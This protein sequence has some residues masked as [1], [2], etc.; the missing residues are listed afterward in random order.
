MR[1]LPLLLLL[2]H[3]VSADRLIIEKVECKRVASGIDPWLKHAVGGLVGIIAGGAVALA[4]GTVVIA[5]DGAMVGTIPV[6]I[7]AI[8]SAAS[9]GNTAAK[10]AIGFIESPTTDTD[11]LIIHVN[12]HKVY[13]KTADYGGIE[14]GDVIEEELS[15]NFTRG[16]EIQLLEHDWPT[17]NDDLGS[18]YVSSDAFDKVAPGENY[19]VNQAVVLGSEEEGSLYLV[20][21]R[22]ERDEQVI[23]GRW[24]LCGTNQCKECRWSM[25]QGADE[26]DV[27][28]D[29]DKSD[30]RPCPFPMVHRGYKTFSMLWPVPDL[31]CRICSSPVL[32]CCGMAVESRDECDCS[33]T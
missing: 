6:T 10:A 4:G 25:C 5:S 26:E 7:G 14:A 3:S 32:R 2:L 29:K 1:S 28:R 30:L 21:Y 22:V 19:R 20:T 27:D 9:G 24:I 16:A 23:V 13:P 15:V 8:I 33:F 31:Y 12:G 18:V 17:E 11:H